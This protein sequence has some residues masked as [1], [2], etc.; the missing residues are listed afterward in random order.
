MSFIKRWDADDVCAQ[1]RQC[2]AQL[3]SHYNDGFTQWACKQDLLR[4]KYELDEILESA[5]RFSNEDKFIEALEQQKTW[6][7]LNAKNP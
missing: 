5:P 7:K 4:I 1:I 3:N 2:S 6:K